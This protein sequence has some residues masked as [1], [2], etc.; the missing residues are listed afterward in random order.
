MFY[1]GRNQTNIKNLFLR[2]NKITPPNKSYW[3]GQGKEVTILL[4]AKNS[5]S[6]ANN[7]SKRTPFLNLMDFGLRWLRWTRGSSTIVPAGLTDAQ[8]WHRRSTT[9]APSSPDLVAPPGRLP[10]YHLFRRTCT[11]EQ[12]R[13]HGSQLRHTRR[14]RH[15]DIG[16]G[17]VISSSLSPTRTLAS[18]HTTANRR[19][20]KPLVLAA[21]EHPQTR[22]IRTAN[23]HPQKP[24]AAE[25]RRSHQG[26]RRRRH[27]R[28]AASQVVG[29]FVK[30]AHS[31]FK[32]GLVGGGLSPRG[33]AAHGVGWAI[34]QRAHLGPNPTFGF[35][36]NFVNWAWI[37]LGPWYNK[38]NLKWFMCSDFSIWLPMDCCSRALQQL[39][40]KI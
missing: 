36:I 14:R 11:R 20:P 3:N 8:P 6:K 16:D 27:N 13:R 34:S 24:A 19:N 10:V 37:Y 35:L 33:W 21:L 22:P 28:G 4:Q 1:K 17:S 12:Q 18:H 25:R 32:H 40:F 39:S 38:I 9:A 29:F 7:R 15:G 30:S 26:R 31:S 2:K 23:G 5:Q